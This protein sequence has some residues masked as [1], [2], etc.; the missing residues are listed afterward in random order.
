MKN[1]IR[2]THKKIDFDMQNRR[3]F[4]LMS[5]LAARAFKK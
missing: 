1:D 5:T 3:T 4:E 2:F